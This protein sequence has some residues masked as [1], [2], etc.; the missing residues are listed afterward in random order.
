M[1]IYNVTT[2]VGWPIHEAWVQWMAQQHIP[3]VLA[4]G[5]FVKHQMV[6]LLDADE[7]EGPTYAVQYFSLT[8]D[9]CTRYTEL[10]ATRLLGES[11]KR[12]G[13]NFIAFKSL[14]EVIN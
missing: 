13:D 3:D 6:R 11:F 1:F 8:K 4:T 7:T 12:W 14:M 2:L 9:D 5:C 10:H